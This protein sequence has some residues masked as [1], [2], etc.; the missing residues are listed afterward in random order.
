M[1]SENQAN[2]VPIVAANNAGVA[3]NTNGGAS[4]GVNASSS[5]FH[6]RNPQFNQ[7]SNAPNVAQGP[8]SSQ[9]LYFDKI[10]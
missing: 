4:P 10:L 9:G 1:S 2:Q 8:S 6:H 5:F 3:V 7:F